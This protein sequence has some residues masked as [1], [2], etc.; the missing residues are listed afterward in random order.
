MLDII[1]H[2]TEIDSTVRIGHL[3]LLPTTLFR[4]ASETVHYID[5]DASHLGYSPPSTAGNALA[6]C[7]SALPPVP[8]VNHLESDVDHLDQLLSDLEDLPPG[9][10][11]TAC[12]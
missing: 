9:R 5:L 11:A 3:L 7:K 8:L 6:H 12:T 10:Q 1:D 4:V 2:V